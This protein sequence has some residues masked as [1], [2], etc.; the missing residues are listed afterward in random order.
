MHH[1]LE[2]YWEVAPHPND[3]PHT[4]DSHA[5]I[6]FNKQKF[7]GNNINCEI[8]VYTSQ[9]RAGLKGSRQLVFHSNSNQGQINFTLD[10]ETSN[11]L[12]K[13]PLSLYLGE[14][15]YFSFV[16][17][18]GA[19][20]MTGALAVAW[21]VTVAVAVAG[22]VVLAVA[23]AGAGAWDGAWA[24]FFWG[25]VAGYI[26]NKLYESL[27]A[28]KNP[29]FWLRFWSRYLLALICGC[30]LGIGVFGSGSIKGFF[31]PAA[32]IP[33]VTIASG[34]GLVYLTLL[35]MLQR[36]SQLA[37][38]RKKEQHLIKP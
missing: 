35:P 34:T 23:G 7:Q 22:A 33:I 20:A 38:Y 15:V 11:P 12:P 27:P 19:L 16:L 30:G 10:I 14:A 37:A 8:T 6:A 2:G 17:A 1:Y 26:L 9:L 36:Q 24:V 31:I 32:M 13:M 21:P 29:S 3:P 5:W 18:S 4:P 28:A 25:A